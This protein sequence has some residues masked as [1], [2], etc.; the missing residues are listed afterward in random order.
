MK[1]IHTSQNLYGCPEDD[2][3]SDGHTDVSSPRSQLELILKHEDGTDQAAHSHEERDGVVIAEEV[4]IVA[5]HQEQIERPKNHVD[6]HKGDDTGVARHGL[7][8]DNLSFVLETYFLNPCDEV[9]TVS[10]AEDV[11]HHHHHPHTKGSRQ[12]EVFRLCHNYSILDFRI[13]AV[14]ASVVEEKKLYPTRPE[15]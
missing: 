6:F 5:E 9:A 3:R 8:D 1:E 11:H 4:L 10:R 14:A 12:D 15:K 7:R 2:D 13:H